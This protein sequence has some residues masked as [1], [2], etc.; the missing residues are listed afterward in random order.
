VSVKNVHCYKCRKDIDALSEEYYVFL[1]KTCIDNEPYCC[2]C[3][4]QDIEEMKELDPFITPLYQK[5]FIKM[6]V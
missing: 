4:E 6:N 3:Y 1:A 5:N 2:K